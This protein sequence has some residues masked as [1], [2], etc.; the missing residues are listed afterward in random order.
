MK[1]KKIA[2]YGLMLALIFTLTAA[3]NM[4]PPLPLLPP[5]VKLGLSNIVTM[6]C[7]FYIGRAPAVGLNALKA[8]FVTLTRAP[9]AGLLSLC[10]GMLSVC[11]VILLLFVF[12]EKLS[13]AAAG[14]SGACAHNIGQ[15]AAASLLL[16][17]PYLLYYLPV[18]L[19]SGVIMGTV[20]G[21]L[22]KVLLPVFKTPPS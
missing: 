5:G 9:V 2:R 16:G 17:T 1:S 13:Y 3:E 21:T 12:R 19:I 14:V 15:Y 22:L 4:L 8:L 20:T 18:L 10:G 11:A 6:Y 7:V